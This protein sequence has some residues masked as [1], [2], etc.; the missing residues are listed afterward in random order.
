MKKPAGLRR[1]ASIVMSSPRRDG[2]LPIQRFQYIRGNPKIEL[3]SLSGLEPARS[4]AL[5]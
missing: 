5:M 3:A 4:T 2:A 1:R